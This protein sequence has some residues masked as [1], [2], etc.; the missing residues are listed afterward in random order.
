MNVASSQKSE[1][2]ENPVDA[3]VQEHPKAVME[4]IIIPADNH[5]VGK[6][7]VE[8][9]FP[10]NAIIAMIKRN[11]KYITP[12]G[13]T[14]INTNDMLI[15]ISDNELAITEVYDMLDMVKD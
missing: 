6:K 11:D 3:I 14:K 4:E 13:S 10:K 9:T 2:D 15:I 5:I 1:N 12:N 8:L 7:I